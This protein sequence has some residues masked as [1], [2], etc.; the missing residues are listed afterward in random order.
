MNL[1]STLFEL[2][3]IALR[4]L[5]R[6]KAK[7]CITCAAIM[8]SVT[9]YIWMQ[10]WLG[11][12]ATESRRNIVNYEMGA[13]KVQSKRYFEKKDELPAYENFSNWE[14]YRQALEAAGYD[15]APRYTFNGTLYSLAGSA[16]LAI[17]AVDPDAEKRALAYADYVN[18]GRF[19]E[20]GEFG[21]VLGAQT[22]DKL[23]LGVPARLAE[24]EL[25]EL[26][27]G[28]DGEFIRGWYQPDT[29]AGEGYTLKSG[30]SAA[31]KARLWGL[32]DTMG[33][34]DVRISTVIDYKDG[35][36]AAGEDVVRHVYQVI[37]AKVVGTVNS[38]DPAT[39][40]NAAYIPLDVLQGEEGMMLEG[41]ITEILIRDKT[42]TPADLTGKRETKAA[43]REAFALTPL[44]PE[45]DVFTW[46]DYAGDYL[47]YETMELGATSIL[48]LLLFFLALTG[49][50][51][52]M[53]LSILERGKEIG[54][55]RALG[56]TDGQLT[57]VYVFEAAALGL[58]GSVLGIILGC[59][60]NY[61]MVKYGIDF[62]EMLEQLNGSMGYRV[63]GNFR[64]M[65]SI[66]VIAGSGI[67]ATI[68]SALTAIVPTRRVL[69]MPIT[70]S[71]RFE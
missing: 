13:A 53:L 67:V 24:K 26:T 54:M 61:P 25:D 9:V 66:P 6:H 45:L 10:S 42:M 40:F 15:A 7:T 59:V 65:W 3:K 33:R 37:D 71:L 1:L 46:E 5:A 11:G 39:N 44:P 36:N 32:F 52:T 62:S 16:P 2:K 41:R 31:D 58:L 18:F 12:M 23:K 57:L 30:L 69:R 68:L 43:I 19:I 14:A 8:I 4:N 38:P 34:N 22:A 47:G 48:S 50:S 49:I 63:V 28:L 35:E 64:S 17:Y 20:P 21:I 60:L 56:M 55:M 27:G 70:D 29:R 51:N